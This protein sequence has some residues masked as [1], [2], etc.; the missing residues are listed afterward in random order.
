MDAAKGARGTYSGPGEGLTVTSLPEGHVPPGHPPEQ[1]P[2]QPPLNETETGD[3]RD[4]QLSTTPIKVTKTLWQRIAIQIGLWGLL[5]K[6]APGEPARTNQITTAKYTIISFLPINLYQQFMRLANLYFL[7]VAFP[8]RSPLL[9][10][11]TG[12]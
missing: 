1:L 6:R 11:R 9:Q 5:N 8:M 10:E 3:Y 4:V 12:F 2:H 7:V